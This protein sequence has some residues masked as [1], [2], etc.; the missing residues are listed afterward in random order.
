MPNSNKKTTDNKY[1]VG[2]RLSDI[3]YVKDLFKGAIVIFGEKYDNPDFY[4]NPF[5]ESYEKRINHNEHTHDEAINNHFHKEFET[6]IKKD[7]NAKFLW[8]RG[9]PFHESSDEIKKRSICVNSSS[10]VNLFADK[11]RSRL[12]ISNYVSVVGTK[13]MSGNNCTY[14]NLCEI[15]PDYDEFILQEPVGS[16]G[17]ISTHI[18]TKHNEDK[19][20]KTIKDKELLISPYYKINIPINHH[21]VIYPNEVIVFPPSVQ[22][23]ERI[24]DKLQYCGGDFV[25]AQGFSSALKKKIEDKGKKIGAILQ[26]LGYRGVLGIDYLLLPNDKILFLEINTRFQASTIALNKALYEK[27]L[28]SI[29]E[30]NLEAFSENVPSKVNILENVNYSIVSYLHSKNFCTNSLI[31]CDIA[32]DKNDNIEFMLDGFSSKKELDDN[33]FLYRLL[34]SSNVS[35]IFENRVIHHPNVFSQKIE[36][37]NTKNKENLIRLKLGLLVHGVHLEIKT[38]EENYRR[39]VGSAF[40]L[41]IDNKLY[42]N[43]FVNTKFSN[44]SPFKLKWITENNF[45]LFYNNNFI[46]EARIEYVDKYAANL[47]SNGHKYYSI[48]QFFT[49]RLRIHPFSGCYYGKCNKACKFCD[50]GNCLTGIEKYE[51]DDVLEV[52]NFYIKSNLPIRH[53]LIGGGTSLE[54]ESWIKIINVVKYIRSLSNR[55]I[56]LM[57]IPPAPIYILDD[58]F[59]AGVSEV[60]FN[61]EFFNREYAQEIMPLKGKISINTYYDTFEYSTKLWGKSGAV[62]SLLMVGIEPIEETLVGIEELCKRGVMPILSLFRPLP[63]TPMENTTPLNYEQVYDLWVKAS[64]ICQKYGFELGPKCI[65]CQNNT[66]SFPSVY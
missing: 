8:Y 32:Y 29:H 40:D 27:R 66:I 11:L 49:D 21:L 23:I 22:L 45:E 20:Q 25:C 14:D 33:S 5:S 10:L 7:F 39:A 30:Y 13:L 35:S 28:P 53:F 59:E 42:V 26:K 6:I 38:D 52:I 54:P 47:T 64:K 58:L 65:P 18:L 37:A 55:D 51:L 24:D 1:W 4:C 31:K 56:Y 15:F 50:L 3:L 41:I 62:R 17:G 16:S 63:N 36:L 61:L 2:P 9:T 44:F 12:L 46:T 34:T 60:G 48:A 57:S 19:I 43:T